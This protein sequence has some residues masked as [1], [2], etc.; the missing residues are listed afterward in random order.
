M[1]KQWWRSS[2]TKRTDGQKGPNMVGS[3]WIWIKCQRI[4]WRST[5]SST[6]WLPTYVQMTEAWGSASCSSHIILVLVPNIILCC[7]GRSL[8]CWPPFSFLSWLDIK[9][10]MPLCTF[11]SKN[12]RDW[13]TFHFFLNINLT[14]QRIRFVRS[15]IRRWN[16]V[17]MPGGLHLY[18]LF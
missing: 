16:T 5:H 2:G 13:S 4:K 6:K 17:E 18:F 9:R 12:L 7:H 11:W 3:E 1:I 10:A 8:S 15:L 14:I